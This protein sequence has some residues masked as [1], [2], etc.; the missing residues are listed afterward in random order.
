MR[1]VIIFTHG[2]DMRTPVADLS[3][4][5]LNSHA[6]TPRRGLARARQRLNGH[7]DDGA[8]TLPQPLVTSLAVAM[9][10]AAEK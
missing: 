9:R 5:I 4:A 6:L 3:A 1:K 7:H 8:Q 10:H 2:R